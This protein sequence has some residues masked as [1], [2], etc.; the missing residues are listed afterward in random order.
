L[1]VAELR[2]LVEPEG[3]VFQGVEV[4]RWQDVVK[5]RLIPTR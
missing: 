3:F 5:F 4:S 2:D 1:S